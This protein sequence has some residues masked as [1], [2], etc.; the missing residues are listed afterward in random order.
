[1][2]DM[3]C[4]LWLSKAFTVNTIMWVRTFSCWLHRRQ[5]LNNVLRQ[6]NIMGR[7]RSRANSNSKFVH[8]PNH[9]TKIVPT[10]IIMSI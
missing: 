4:L 1:M 3:R 2:T 9:L 6:L 5:I 7:Q 10:E 8:Q